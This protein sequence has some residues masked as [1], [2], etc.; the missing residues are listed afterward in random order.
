MRN[1]E[2]HDQPN[3]MSAIYAITMCT[4]LD[5]I[6]TA[7]WHNPHQQHLNEKGEQSEA[8]YC[9]AYGDHLADMVWSRAF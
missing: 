8:G 1:S 2:Y 7:E 5:R 9:R 3:T 4:H 6:V